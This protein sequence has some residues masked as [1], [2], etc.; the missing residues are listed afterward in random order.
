MTSSDDLWTSTS[1]AYLRPQNGVDAWTAEAATRGGVGTQRLLKVET[2][3]PPA[4]IEA[5]L[6]LR[7]SEAATLRLRL[8]ELDGHPVEIASS[9]YPADI[10][11]GTGLA[12]TKKIRGGAPQLLADLGRGID[13]VVED[14]ESRLP[15]AEEA[16]MLHMDPHQPVLVLYRLARDHDDRPVEMSV[17]VTP[18]SQRRL[19]YEMKVS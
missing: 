2:I 15:T 17:M 11:T 1:M 7:S 12:D 6:E 3:K 19:R 18:G 9:W 4:A 8:I 14:V 13:S 16:G 10:A 5:A